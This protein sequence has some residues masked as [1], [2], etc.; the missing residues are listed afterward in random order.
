MTRKNKPIY[1]VGDLVELARFGYPPENEEDRVYGTVIE[2]VDSEGTNYVPRY[3]VRL[4]FG[5]TNSVNPFGAMNE[6]DTRIVTVL[7]YDMLLAT[8]GGESQED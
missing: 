6:R 4:L 7:E 2:S 8:N 1:S 5:K 3:R